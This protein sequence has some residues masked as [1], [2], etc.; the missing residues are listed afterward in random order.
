MITFGI[1]PGNL[2][3]EIELIK[4]VYKKMASNVVWNIVITLSENG[5]AMTEA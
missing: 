1:K 3:E 2:K 4:M 5:G